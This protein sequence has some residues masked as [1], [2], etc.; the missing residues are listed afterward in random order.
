MSVFILCM[1]CQPSW[2]HLSLLVWIGLSVL[3]R[4]I[5]SLKASWTKGGNDKMWPTK[6]KR[7]FYFLSGFSIQSITL[8]SCLCDIF[9]FSLHIGRYILHDIQNLTNL[10]SISL[11]PSVL[12][13][14]IETCYFLFYKLCSDIF[15]ARMS[16]SRK[17]SI[18]SSLFIRDQVNLKIVLG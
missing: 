4:T 16:I 8:G 15:F 17:I 5:K 9:H 6:K 13:K 3:S 7:L 18:F 11:S 10:T 1:S 12:F 14:I 2:G